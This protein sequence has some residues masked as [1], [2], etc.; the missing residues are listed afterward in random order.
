MFCSSPLREKH[1]SK[2]HEYLD[3]LQQP[4]LTHLLTGLAGEG[5]L[6]PGLLHLYILI[7]IQP[8]LWVPLHF[9]L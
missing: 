6:H 4:N 9:G 5:L 2:T 7:L 3:H 1:L 8:F